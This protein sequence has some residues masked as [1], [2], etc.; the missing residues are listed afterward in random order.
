MM[1]LQ[2]I[3]LQ[4][5]EESKNECLHHIQKINSNNQQLRLTSTTASVGFIYRHIAETTVL[6]AQ[7]FGY[8]TQVQ[9]STMGQQ[10]TG[11]EYDLAESEQIFH[12]G[13]NSLE[14]LLNETSEKDWLQEIET[15]WFGKISRIKLYSILLFH[16]AH[17]C[18]QMASALANG[19]R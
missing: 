17:H 11:I 18:G 19:H 1:M 14:M 9:G 16:N 8:P 2:Q 13:Y 15:S 10:D 7:F 3:M 5:L 6:I 12:E 4:Q